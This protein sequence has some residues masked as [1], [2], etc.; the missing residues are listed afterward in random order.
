MNKVCVLLLIV[1]LG[2]ML[3]AKGGTSASEVPGEAPELT[4]TMTDSGIQYVE[5][6]DDVNQNKY[7]L[8]LGE[9]TNTKLNFTLLPWQEWQQSLNLVLA[10]EEYT[11][12]MQI[13]G[14]NSP[15][16][17][18][19]I[20]AGI[21]MPLNDLIDKHAPNLKK[22]IP[23]E[24][25]DDPMI[26]K[27]GKIYAIPKLAYPRNFVVVY[28]RRDWLD[29]LGLRDPVTV[30]DY[31][32]MWRAFRDSKPA[33]IEEPVPFSCREQF[34]CGD[35]IFAAYDV[36][37]NDWSYVNGQLVPNFI[38]PEIKEVLEIY[39]QMYA[40]MLLDNEFLVQPGRQWD[41]KIKGQGTVGS[42]IHVAHYPDKWLIEVQNNHPTADVDVLPYPVGP[43]GRGGGT[44]G[45]A[46]NGLV[47]AIPATNENPE[48]A[49]KFLDSFWIKEVT[50][51][52]TYGIEGDNYTIENN[53]A[54]YS[55]PTDQEGM[56]EESMYQIWLSLIGGPSH[57]QNEDYVRGR[58]HGDLILKALKI[59]S[60]Q[61]RENDGLGMPALPTILERPELAFNG[62]FL[63]FAAKVVTGKTPVE[64]FDSFVKDWKKR[65]GDKLITEATEWY[66]SK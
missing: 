34:V 63:E 40:E 45:P 13:G 57:L 66:Q 8:K 49:I 32:E 28:V 60:S 9:L 55:Y 33:G 29:E 1:L 50:T 22:N 47:Y 46:I 65:G 30:D 15:A 23:K 26:S 41:A 59:A 58:P 51:F 36:L 18:P 21:F 56:Y 52:L 14:I 31:M 6:L 11:D 4:I 2:T 54:V 43:D 5:A 19:S 42:W 35:L 61:G 27:D 38:R 7:I 20:E 3:W 16:I 64:E 62:L 53:K 10:G 39:R 37:P 12:I 24:I 44:K 25:W 48:V 17:A